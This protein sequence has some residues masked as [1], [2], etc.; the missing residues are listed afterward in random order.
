MER[1]TLIRLL[2]VLGIGIPL[3]VEGFT[4]FGLL[5]AQLLGGGG[6]ATPTPTVDGVTQGEEVLRATAPTD[7]LSTASLAG[8]G[9]PVLT[10]TVQVD[11]TANASY[12]LRLTGVT[13]RDGETVGGSASTGVLAPGE[14][15]FATGQWTLP[16][17]ARPGSV[18]VVA[19]TVRDGETAR[20][21]RSVTLGRLER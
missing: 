8:N 16:A 3:L 9:Q 19:T 18:S 4:F 10:L 11:N 20:I 15:G 12:E 2:V 14:S 17:G 21:E 5:E 7:T 1:R 13:T 6:D